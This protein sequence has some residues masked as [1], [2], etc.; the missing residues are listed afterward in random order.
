MNPADVLSRALPPPPILEVTSIG[1]H[2]QP[3]KTIPREGES[4]QGY[5]G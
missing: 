3:S 1:S 2:G 5:M 4:K